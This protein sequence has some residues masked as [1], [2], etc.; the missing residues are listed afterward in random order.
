MR[1]RYVNPHAISTN[2]ASSLC[3]KQ[4]IAD[5]QVSTD[6]GR[7]WKGGLTRQDYNFFENSSGFGTSSVDVRVLS[8]DGDAVVVKNVAVTSG[9]LVTGSRNF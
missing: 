9:N 5:L 2:C 3:C 1:I 4:A 7:T 6:G 8:V